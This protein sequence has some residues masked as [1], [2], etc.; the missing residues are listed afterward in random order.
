M[1]NN[2]EKLTIAVPKGRVLEEIIPLFESMKLSFIDNPFKSRKLI[3]KTTNPK[4][5]IILL[6][7]HDVATYVKSGVADLG[8]S[9]LDVL[10]EMNTSN[11]FYLLDLNI[12]KC[13]MVVAAPYD[14]DY[15]SIVKS[16]SRISVASKYIKIAT[17]FFYSKGVHV[18]MIK[19]YG[20]MELA[21]ILKLSEIIVDLV[22]TGQTIKANNLK[23]CEKIMEISS[24][25]ISNQFAYK[26][27]NELIIKFMKQLE[28]NIMKI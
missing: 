18:D 3:F 8:I 15:D 14:Y 28:L 25:L 22:S 21:P 7:P 26:F 4:I 1:F 27:K 19:L 20:S 10:H 6:R 11:L 2:T 13:K 9:G 16:G 24:F 12:G 17:N 23:I 5:R